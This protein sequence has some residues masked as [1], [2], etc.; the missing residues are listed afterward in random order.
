MSIEFVRIL[1]PICH[2]TMVYFSLAELQ[3]SCCFSSCLSGLRAWIAFNYIHEY[4][5]TN[6]APTA[7]DRGYGNQSFSLR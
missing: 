6:F 4:F 3:Q 5:S 2:V 7:S 1:T